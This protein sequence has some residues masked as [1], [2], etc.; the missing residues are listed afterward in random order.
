M[1]KSK[2][3]ISGGLAIVIAGI[4]VCGLFATVNGIL[5]QDPN[6]LTFGIGASIGGMISILL[7]NNKKEIKKKSAKKGGFAF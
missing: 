6:Y 4:I 3:T 7:I 1:K 5:Q 2:K